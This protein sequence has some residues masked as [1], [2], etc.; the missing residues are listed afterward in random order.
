MAILRK[1]HNLVLNLLKNKHLQE[2]KNHAYVKFEDANCLKNDY[3]KLPWEIKKRE[4][5]SRRAGGKE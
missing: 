2:S 4:I 5:R 3:F 1:M